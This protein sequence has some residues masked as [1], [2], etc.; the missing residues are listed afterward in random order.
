LNGDGGAGL[1]SGPRCGCFAGQQQQAGFGAGFSAGRG[2]SVQHHPGGNTKTRALIRT[3]VL[4]A[5]T[6]MSNYTSRNRRVFARW[7]FLE[8]FFRDELYQL[9]TEGIKPLLRLTLGPLK[10]RIGDL[11]P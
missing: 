7:R 9:S 10:W 4:A 1:G 8:R 5:T 2:T 6:P 3:S 11:N